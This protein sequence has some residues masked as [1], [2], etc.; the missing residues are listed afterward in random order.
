MSCESDGLAQLLSVLTG[1]ELPALLGLVTIIAP[2]LAVLLVLLV[3]EFSGLLPLPLLV[4][5]KLAVWGGTVLQLPVGLHLNPFPVT[6]QHFQSFLI[7]F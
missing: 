4:D 2:E 7:T 1:L 5:S 6:L 3:E